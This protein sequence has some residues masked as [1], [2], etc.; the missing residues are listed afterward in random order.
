MIFEKKNLILTRKCLANG[1]I[2][3]VLFSLPIS[4]SKFLA[5]FSSFDKM[6]WIVFLQAMN[7]VSGNLTHNV[8]VLYT[9]PKTTLISYNAP[10]A[11]DFDGSI[12]SSLGTSYF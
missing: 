12:I 8:R 9:H 11:F 4:V 10:S 5:F 2:D 3:A 7:L 6:S 1:L